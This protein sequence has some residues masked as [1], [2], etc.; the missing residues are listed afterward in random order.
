ALVVRGEREIEIGS[1]EVRVGDLVRLRPGGRVPVDGRVMAGHSA[2]D[3][4][5]VT[6]E[7]MPV[8]KM[9][10]DVVIGGSING[11]GTVLIR[12]TAVGA[13]T[14]L[15]Q[16]VRHVEGAR[17]LEAGILHLVGRILRVYAPAVVILAPPSFV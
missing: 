8:E 12:V 16:V 13:G 17:A 10:G 6:G 3:E 4:S 9:E 2:V 11:L 1:E 14:F 7:P 5:F 15:Q